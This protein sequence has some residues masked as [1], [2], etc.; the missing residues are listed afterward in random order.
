MNRK[1]SCPTIDNPELKNKKKTRLIRLKNGHYR[2]IVD[3]S[4]I[5]KLD[6]LPISCT[7][8]C[9]SPRQEEKEEKKST[10][11][12]NSKSSKEDKMSNNSLT[13]ER[14]CIDVI[15]EKSEGVHTIG[16]ISDLS[17]TRTSMKSIENVSLKVQSEFD[18]EELNQEEVEEEYANSEEE[19]EEVEQEQEEE[20]LEQEQEE[21]ELEQEEEEEKEEEEEEEE[22]DDDE[23]FLD[24]KKE[25]NVEV[26]PEEK[27]LIAPSKTLMKGTKTN[28]YFLS[29]KEM[30]QALMCY[31]YK[32]N[33]VVFEKDTFLRYLYMKS[34]NNIILNERMIEQLCKQE[35][36][37]YVLASNSIVVESTDFLKPLII[38]F[39]S[40]ISKKVFVNHIK[41]TAQN[42]IDM[43]KF[44]E[45]FDELHPNEKL[46]LSKVERFHSLNVIATNN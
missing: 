46:R 28:I 15:E 36:L 40:S 39:E 34:I 42:E 18:E 23:D 21:E 44:S 14:Y 19:E 41:Y 1:F 35:N 38:E 29:N 27:T 24:E 2:R 6:I 37:K 25:E 33:A 13:D 10:E 17:I 22:D 3:I 26:P 30:V 45:Y 5:D 12:Q 11:S 43:N 7:F 31:N 9:P 4:N 20:E 16:T 32:C 8:A